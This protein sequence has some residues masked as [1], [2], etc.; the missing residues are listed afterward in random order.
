MI[1]AHTLDAWTRAADRGSI[2]FRNATVLGGFA[3]PLFLWLAGLASVLSAARAAEKSGSRVA[4]LDAIC[5][6][7]LEIFI[8]AFLFRLQ[9]F[10]ISPGS[11]PITLFRVDILNIMGPAIVGAGIIWW[12]AAS[13][14]PQA[15]TFAAIAAVIAMATPIIREAP[16][17]SALPV[18]MQWYIRPAG[19]HTTFT[20]FPWIGFVFAGGACGSLLAGVRGAGERRVHVGLA[21]TGA[22]LVAGGFYASTLPTIYARSSFWTSSPT[23]FAIRVGVLQLGL[24][25]IFLAEQVVSRASWSSADSVL[26]ALALSW[27]RPLTTLGRNSLFVYWIH[28]ELVYG[29]ASWLWRGRLP[30]WGTAVGWFAFSALMYRVVILTAAFRDRRRIGSAN[31]PWAPAARHA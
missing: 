10:I 2:A 19:E 25:A 29:Y 1:E 31:R 7:G 17:V 8:L 18:W 22:A 14:R 9:A 27:Q 3:A 24:A 20:A 11:H 4:A 23:W 30:L 6:R 26:T 16:I 28:V 15:A 12:S 5:R 13:A 21:L